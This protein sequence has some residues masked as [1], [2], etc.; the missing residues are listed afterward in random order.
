MTIPPDAWGGG[1]FGGAS[2]EPLG[3][4]SIVCCF[5]GSKQEEKEGVLDFC[6]RFVAIVPLDMSREKNDQGSLFV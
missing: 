3:D 4:W 1:V 2:P 6:P 5:S